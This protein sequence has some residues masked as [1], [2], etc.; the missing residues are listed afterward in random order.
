MK[1]LNS[2]TTSQVTMQTD[3]NFPNKTKM[4]I[5]ENHAGWIL[6]ST[7]VNTDGSLISQVAFQHTS[8]TE[9]LALLKE[10]KA[11]AKNECQFTVHLHLIQIL[12]FIHGDF[13]ACTYPTEEE[14]EFYANHEQAL[15]DA[16]KP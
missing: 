1:T 13:V 12:V 3:S 14:L 11:W 9:M 16:N 15:I 8:S 4:K 7:T 5:K 6:N 10:R 2:A